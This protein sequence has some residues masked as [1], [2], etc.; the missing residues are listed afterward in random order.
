M[1]Q[2]NFFI[3]NGP[4]FT[5]TNDISN[6][7]ILYAYFKLTKGNATNLFT[8]PLQNYSQYCDKTLII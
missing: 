2:I 7:I 6:K 8:I 3:I 4:G 5:P 1:I